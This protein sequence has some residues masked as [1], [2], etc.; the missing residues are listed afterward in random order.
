MADRIEPMRHQVDEQ[1]R[2]LSCI[3]ATTALPPQWRSGQSE[4]RDLPVPHA[5]QPTDTE[6]LL[7]HS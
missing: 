1:R 5:K 6:S 3:P 4:S 7:G 2:G